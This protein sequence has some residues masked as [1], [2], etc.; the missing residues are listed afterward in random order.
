[1]TAAHLKLNFNFEDAQMNFEHSDDASK[2]L[3]IKYNYVYDGRAKPF[4]KIMVIN[5]FKE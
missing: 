3:V 2:N 5:R 4:R 1:M